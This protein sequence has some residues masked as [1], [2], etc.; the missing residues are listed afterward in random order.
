M[1]ARREI[2]SLG[3][4][5]YFGPLCYPMGRMHNHLNEHRLLKKTIELVDDLV[6]GFTFLAILGVVS[7]IGYEIYQLILQVIAFELKHVLEIV[8]LIIIL[9]KA[10]RLLLFYM[11][12]HHV[13]VRYI[14]EIS[15]I[16]P[17]VEL[18]FNPHGRD[19]WLNVLYAVFAI[20]NL[21]IYA[22][23]CGKLSAYDEQSAEGEI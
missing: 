14:V 10:Y 19:M 4:F 7:F 1:M 3:R 16:A 18:I 17:A 9:I 5:F 12:S 6:S 13:A 21:I 23:S 8:A 20:A 11:K 22:F 15:I 2:G